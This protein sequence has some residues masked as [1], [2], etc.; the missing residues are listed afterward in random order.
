M[1][2]LD[3]GIAGTLAGVVLGYLLEWFREWSRD[4]SR[5]KKERVAIAIKILREVSYTLDFLKSVLQTLSN[6]HLQSKIQAAQFVTSVAPSGYSVFS[7]NAVHNA[8][9]INPT[10]DAQL[11]KFR[12]YLAQLE[13]LGRE[14][15]IH[16]T[17]SIAT[18][19]QITATY[20]EIGS[21]NEKAQK[22]VDRAKQL[23]DTTIKHGEQIQQQL[24]EQLKAYV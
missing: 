4:K 19:P 15:Q 16:I 3:P 24:E 7:L 10:L 6:P 22:F 14:I 11:S 23:I 9:P 13:A 21:L 5:E 12:S 8:P 2:I 17:P 18:P 1:Q 20:T